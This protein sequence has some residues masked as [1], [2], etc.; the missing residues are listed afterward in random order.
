MGPAF[1]LR[2]DLV[3]QSGR[4]RPQFQLRSRPQ[5]PLQ[6][7]RQSLR[8]LKDS[9]DIRLGWD[10]GPRHLCLSGDLGGPD[11]PSG[12]AHQASA[13]ASHI[14]SGDYIFTS[15]VTCFQDQEAVVHW[16]SHPREC[17]AP[18]QRVPSGVVLRCPCID[19]R[20]QIQG[21][22]EVDRALL[23]A[24]VHEAEAVLLPPGGYAALPFDDIPGSIWSA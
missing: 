13:I 19:G 8:S 23:F 1:G 6:S 15:V 4:S 12:P 24:T 2:S 20:F 3:H 22:D 9:D 18:P 5:Y 11:P 7:L 10:P 14:R 21:F 16:E 17:T